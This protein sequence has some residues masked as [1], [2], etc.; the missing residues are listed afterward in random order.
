M[1]VYYHIVAL[2]LYLQP[3]E[4]HRLQQQD[5]L[6][7]FCVCHRQA[8]IISSQTCS[9]FK[10]IN[11]FLAFDLVVLVCLWI[12]RSFLLRPD[13]QNPY[14]PQ[15]LLLHLKQSPPYQHPLKY[16]QPPPAFSSLSA[17]VDSSQTCPRMEPVRRECEL[18][19]T[20]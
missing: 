11:Y 8:S 6:L 2:R 7:C 18:C 9:F 17:A 19:P 15:L 5:R 12:Q 10:S 3:P 13:S 20:H 4:G 16:L 14:E 1:Y